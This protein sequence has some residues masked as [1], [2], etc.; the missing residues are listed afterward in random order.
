MD[1]TLVLFTLVTA[2]A[3]FGAL[4][5]RFGIDSREYV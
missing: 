4:A 3:A 1:T 2:L 5:L